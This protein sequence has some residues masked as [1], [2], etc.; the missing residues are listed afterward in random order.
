MLW[1]YERLFELRVIL[2][3]KSASYI[4]HFLCVTVCAGYLEF[5]SI[6]HRLFELCEKSDI[7][8]GIRIDRLPVVSNGNNLRIAYL[9]QCL[10]QIKPLARDILI[11]IYDDILEVKCLSGYK[12]LIQNTCRLINH[13]LK[14]YCTFLLQTFRIFKVALLADIKEKSCSL[15]CCLALPLIELVNGI[16][17]GLEVLNECAD[18]LYKLQDILVL[19]CVDNLFKYLLR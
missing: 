8:T 12:L 3:N 1:R 18:K 16:S 7:R 14:V 2:L 15:I 13:I 5:L 10:R 9:A 6:S 4:Y 17:V 19:F 11:L